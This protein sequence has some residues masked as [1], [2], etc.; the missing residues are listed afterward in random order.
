MDLEGGA[1]GTS[2]Y[3]FRA[4]QRRTFGVGLGCGFTT[5]GGLLTMI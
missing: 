1:L 2:F 5:A 4:F 3:H